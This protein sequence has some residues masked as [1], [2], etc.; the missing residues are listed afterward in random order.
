MW[1]LFLSL[2]ASVKDGEVSLSLLLN[3]VRNAELSR[4]EVQILIDL[5]LNK[6]HEAP[7][8][9]TEWTEVGNLSYVSQ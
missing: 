5:L 6:Q 2:K 3:A 7:A 8:T 9:L 1:Q 4:S